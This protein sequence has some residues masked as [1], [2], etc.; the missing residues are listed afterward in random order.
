MLELNNTEIRA[1]ISSVYKYGLDA[2]TDVSKLHRRQMKGYLNDRISEDD[3]THHL[4]AVKATKENYPKHQ[5]NAN[6]YAEINQTYQRNKS[7]LK[8]V[9]KS[10]EIDT[11]AQ[12]K[13]FEFINNFNLESESDVFNHFN[14]RL[15]KAGYCNEENLQ[16]FLIAAF[17]DMT[18]PDN[19][20]KLIDEY[21]QGVRNTFHEFYKKSKH[22]KGKN[23]QSY[24]QL[25]CDYF[26][27][28]KLET[29]R[30]NWS[31]DGRKVY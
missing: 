13:D 9:E 3:M 24:C 15:V 6:Y 30:T 2:L 29:V 8:I 18:I 21:K 22:H 16:T 19:K 27:G 5:C 26:D 12:N 23:A 25:L 31:K 4:T 17:Q 1:L 10:L 20:I 11:K 28:Y 14:D 7:V